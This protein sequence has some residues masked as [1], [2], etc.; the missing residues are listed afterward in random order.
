VGGFAYYIYSSPRR[1]A[2]SFKK[3]NYET[4]IK[5]RRGLE[6]LG[7]PV[8]LMGFDVGEITR[9]VPNGPYDYYNITVDFR[10]RPQPGIHLERFV[11]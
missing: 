10:V 2:G 1:K 5:K 4:S 7:E 9:I 6:R 11:P 3:F 8:K